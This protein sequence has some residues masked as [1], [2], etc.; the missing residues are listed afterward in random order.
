M[1]AGC[2]AGRPTGRRGRNARLALN[3]AAI[4]NDHRVR[5]DS[6]LGVPDGRKTV[7]PRGADRASG[8]L[9]ARR[10]VMSK[11]GGGPR[12]PN[13]DGVASIVVAMGPRKSLAA[14]F[15]G[16]VWTVE[17]RCGPTASKATRPPSRAQGAH[18]P[19]ELSKIVANSDERRGSNRDGPASPP[20]QMHELAQQVDAHL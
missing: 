18:L 11:R 6:R 1:T 17:T 15:A 12:R 20:M 19:I 4:G 10:I 14:P 16:C 3:A 13:G 2:R 8:P 7:L 5:R 9:C